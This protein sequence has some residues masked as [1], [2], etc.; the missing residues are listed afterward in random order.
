M[1]RFG[2]LGQLPK[3]AQA[4]VNVRILSGDHIDTVKFVALNTG[5]ITQDELITPGVALSGD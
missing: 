5:L 3:D 1:L 2:T 4:D